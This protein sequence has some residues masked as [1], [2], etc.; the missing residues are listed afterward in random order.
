MFAF[1]LEQST[2]ESDEVLARRARVLS[3][4]IATGEFVKIH[5]SDPVAEMLFQGAS[6]R[7]RPGNA[8]GAIPEVL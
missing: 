3:Y 5:G 7:V 8:A 2:R 4:R 6:F 1:R